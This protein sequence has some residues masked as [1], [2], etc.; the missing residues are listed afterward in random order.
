MSGHSKW[1]SIKHKKGALDAKRG[2]IFTKIIRELTVSARQGGGDPNTNPSLRTIIA[3]AKASNMPQDNIERA[4]K[5]GTGELEGVTYEE[6]TYEGYGAQGAA[7]L[8][9]CLTD[10]KN[11]TAADIRNI[12]N[13]CN[14]SMAGAGSVAWMF[15]KKGLIQI[16]SS[17]M[18][19]DK[20]MEIALNAGAEDFENDEGSFVIK[21]DPQNFESIKQAILDANLKPDSAEI[22]MVPKN[23]VEVEEGN[24]KSILKLVETLEDHDDVQNAYSNFNISEAIL[25]KLAE[26]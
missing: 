15:E 18:E 17:Q 14:G 4:I 11:R 25:K 19:E 22:T 16:P 13:K 26:E 5:R 9:T 8:V 12:F 24:A 20:V 3:K 2:K 6:I 1:A 21:T 7:I 10:N 23:T